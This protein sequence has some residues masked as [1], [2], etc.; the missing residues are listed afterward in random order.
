MISTNIC[1]SV[2]NQIH[3]W[4]LIIQKMVWL[5]S[6]SRIWHKIRTFEKYYDIQNTFYENHDLYMHGRCGIDR[7]GMQWFIISH[8]LPRHFSDKGRKPR[9][10]LHWQESRLLVWHH[11]SGESSVVVG[12][13]YGQEK[14]SCRLSYRSRWWC[15]SSLLSRGMY[16]ISWQARA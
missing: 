4:K 13:E 12:M 2:Q 6:I 15:T 3:F 14:G 10:F 1:Q 5:C 9:I 8:R 7:F 16:C 11:S